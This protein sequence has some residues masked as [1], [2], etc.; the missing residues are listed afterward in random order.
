MAVSHQ[1][2]QLFLKS[3]QNLYTPFIAKDKKRNVFLQQWMSG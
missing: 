1:E 2:G 3:K